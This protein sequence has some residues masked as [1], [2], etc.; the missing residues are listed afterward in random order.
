MGCLMVNSTIELAAEDSE[1]ARVVRRHMER[2]GIEKVE[3][4]ASRKNCWRMRG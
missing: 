2:L 3:S 1:V 4:F